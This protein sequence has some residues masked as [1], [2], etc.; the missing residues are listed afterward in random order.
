MR[1]FLY[2][3]DILNCVSKG[4]INKCFTSS[5]QLPIRGC[6]GGTHKKRTI[7]KVVKPR[8]DIHLNANFVR[9]VNKSNLVQIPLISSNHHSNNLTRIATWNA[10]SMKEKVTHVCD[11][12]ISERLEILAVTEA[13]L[14][15]EFKDD[16]VLADIKATL[17]DYNIY[18]NPR[19]GRKGGGICVISRK[20]F[21]VK[22]C[23]STSSNFKTFQHTDLVITSAHNLPFRLVTIYRP[24]RSKVNKTTVSQFLVDFSS[25]LEDL[26]VYP[27]KLAVVGDFNIHVDNPNDN[28]ACSFLSIL[29]SAGLVQ[30]VKGVTHKDGHTLDLIISRQEDTFVGDTRIIHGLKSDHSAVVCKLGVSRP[31]PSKCVVRSRNLRDINRSDL[32]NDIKSSRLFKKSSDKDLSNLV[33]D[34]N[35]VLRESLEKHA[36]VRERE[37]SLRPHAPWYD[38]HLRES[39]RVKRRL[40]RKWV[41]TDLTVD[42][43]IYQAHCC[44]YRK[45]LESAKRTFYR[46]KFSRC[47]QRQ[48]FRTV[49]K[50]SSAKSAKTLPDSDSLESLTSRFHDFF[51]S[52]VEK[53]RSKLVA[54][55]PGKMSVNITESCTT[56]FSQFRPV[57]NDEVRKI[58][59]DSSKTSCDLDP[60]PTNL[61]AEI[62]EAPLPAITKIINKSFSSGE[63]PTAL[64]SALISPLI[65]KPSLDANELANYRPISNLPF[66][67]KVLERVAVQQLQQYMS[68][69]KLHAKA[70]SAYRQFHSTE[71]A[72][73]RVTND[74]LRAVDQHDEV[75]LVLL[76]LSA[77]FD[78]IDHQALLQRL[79]TRFGIRDTA[80]KWLTS[81]F[82]NR[83]QSVLIDGV[84]S[85]PKEVLRGAPQGSV[86]GPLAFT[87]YISAIEKIVKAHG[88]QCIIYAD[89]TQLYITFNRCDAKQIIPVIERCVKDIKCWMIVNMLM[90]NDSKTEILHFKSR[91]VQSVDIP[92]IQIGDSEV[93]TTSAARNLGVIL[94]SNMTM[95]NHVKSIC[96]SA[97][98]ALYRIG[99][100]RNFLDQ[101]STEKLVHAFITSRLDSCNSL[102]FGL[103]DS[104][105]DKLQRVQNSAARLV[106]RVRGRCHMKPVLRRLHWL[107]IRKRILFKI[108]LITFKAIHDLA[109]DYIKDLIKIRKPPRVLRSS[110]ATELKRPPTSALK[111]VTYG[112]RAFS[113]A[114]PELWNELPSSIR[115][116]STVNQFKSSLKTHLFMLPD[117]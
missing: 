31:Y 64:K 13:W 76:D 43:Q 109:P 104:E 72:L 81:Y 32:S 105:L 117:D 27:G 99:K 71:T 108:L 98:F 91:F 116:V 24:P 34:F 1:P 39:K 14:T 106:T 36:P 65:K 77:A 62:I 54:T 19:I 68:V 60:M 66:L 3:R 92:S 110:C 23:S 35:C 107:P 115:N 96:K 41:K 74:I 59:M 30:H 84:K 38:N 49:D 11:L 9:C 94:D 40:E 58:I 75:V 25:L 103:P 82:C 113:A 80:F 21:Q 17:P 52:K 8:K 4:V 51:D 85:A 101:Q 89:D 70:Q 18:S 86:F 6:R 37:I 33:D 15:G 57:T 111:T 29:G 48:L 7:Q 55:D 112:Y 83:R 44:E 47:N 61:L 69:N 90:L 79:S 10:R 50:L 67:H 73:I 16:H 28:D 2:G 42:K 100:I 53:I 5:F 88:L 114:A 45:D 87:M 63:I 20:G 95:S 12:I 26:A 46:N 56:K 93:E 97:S 102:L 78:T 22:E